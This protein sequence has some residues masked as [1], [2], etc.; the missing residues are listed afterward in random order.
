MKS[1]SLI[2]SVPQPSKSTPS[3]SFAPCSAFTLVEVLVSMAILSLVVVAIYSSW[4]AI[5][6]ASKVGLDAAAE[7]QRSRIAL[8]T[9]E[10]SLST[11]EL[12]VRNWDYYGFLAENGSDA[13][14]SFV[15]RL[16]KSFPRSGRFGDFDLRRL[17][18]TVENGQNGGK[19]LVLRQQPIV[20][21]LDEDEKNYPLVLARNVKEFAIEFWDP[22]VQDWIDEWRQ[23]NQLPKLIKITLS[24]QHLDSRSVQTVDEAT[25][26]IALTS[27]GVPPNFQTPTPGMAPGLPGIGAP[28]APPVIPSP[29]P[30]QIP[31]PPVR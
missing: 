19:E 3:G 14:L 7:A 16:P 24:T 18:Y 27:S 1:A 26:V 28:G 17:T 29:V 22:R 11:V 13:T 23:T 30:P 6:R 8:H 2:H 12:F 21:D 20:M 4:T 25:R 10:D 5:L 31:Q 9:L 15:A